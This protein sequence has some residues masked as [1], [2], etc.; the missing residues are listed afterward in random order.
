MKSFLLL[1][2]LTS[3]AWSQKPEDHTCRILFLNGPDT[4]PEKLILFD[5]VGAQ[6]VELPRLN[7]SPVYKLRSGDLSLHLLKNIPSDPKA[8]P[9]GAPSVNVPAGTGDF[10]LILTSDP[11]NTVVP[12]HAQVVNATGNQLGRGEMLWFNLTQKTIA[13]QV[14]TEKV[15]LKPS[16]RTVVK[17]PA[18]VKEDHAVDLYFRLPD[19]DFVYPLCK[20]RWRHDPQVRKLVFIFEEGK[21]RSPRIQAFTDYRMPVKSDSMN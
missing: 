1:L 12:V 17:A 16:S 21:H 6:E 19:D 18:N 15:V 14:G 20:T 9:E 8:I 5:G 13:G 3:I 2:L 11:S 7:L 10:Y 4:A